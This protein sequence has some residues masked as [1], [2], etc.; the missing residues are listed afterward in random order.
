MQNKLVSQLESLSGIFLQQIHFLIPLFF[1]TSFFPFFHS[2]CLN[3]S[4]ND[5]LKTLLKISFIF[6]GC[7]SFHCCR[8]MWNSGI[9]QSFIVME[10]KPE[11][12]APWERTFIFGTRHYTNSFS[13]YSNMLQVQNILHDWVHLLSSQWWWQHL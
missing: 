13:F 3:S 10:V 5:N 2:V 4:E 1:F 11:A 9:S 6:K 7:I 12:I 8:G